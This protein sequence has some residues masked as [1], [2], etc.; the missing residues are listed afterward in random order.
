MERKATEFEKQQA[1]EE[2]KKSIKA[3]YSKGKKQITIICIIEL[4]LIVLSFLTYFD[5]GSLIIGTALCG[6]LYLGFSWI[7]YLYA[8]N[9]AL[10]AF[11]V[12]NLVF[13]SQDSSFVAIVLVTAIYKIAVAVL[14]FTSEAISEFLYSQQN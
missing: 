12:F 11:V 4:I 9:S 1:I 5:V 3:E 10:T 7:R 13:F 8:L 2:V 14:L 6:G